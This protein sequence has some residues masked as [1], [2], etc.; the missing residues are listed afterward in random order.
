MRS[1]DQQPQPPQ[2][3][4]QPPQ[5]LQPQSLPQPQPPQHKRISMIMMIQEQP[6]PKP[7]HMIERLLSFTVQNMKVGEMCDGQNKTSKTFLNLGV[8]VSIIEK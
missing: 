2:P 3:L 8:S 7:L 6:P 4:L 5:L 1:T